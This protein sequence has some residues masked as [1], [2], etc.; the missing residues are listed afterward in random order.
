MAFN[1]ALSFVDWSF[2]LEATS[3]KSN[4]KP[5]TLANQ[6]PWGGFCHLIW[7]GALLGGHTSP[8]RFLGFASNAWN[9]R[10]PKWIFHDVLYTVW[11]KDTKY[12][13]E[14]SKARSLFELQE[15]LKDQLK[16]NHCDGRVSRKAEHGRLAHAFAFQKLG[17]HSRSQSRHSC[18]YRKSRAKKGDDAPVC[19]LLSKPQCIRYSKVNAHCETIHKYGRTY[20]KGWKYF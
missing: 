19:F 8:Q 12:Y 4:N 10:K 9:C 15:S 16:L 18:P 7:L 1:A 17:L 20:P 2:V 6:P 11:V 13:P 3:T 14:R 5:A